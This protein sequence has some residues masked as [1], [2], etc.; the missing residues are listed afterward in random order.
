[1]FDSKNLQQR[2]IAGLMASLQV[3]TTPITVVIENVVKIV[4]VSTISRA[5]KLDELLI[6]H[7]L[8][9]ESSHYC[10]LHNYF[11]ASNR[12]R[13]LHAPVTRLRGHRTMVAQRHLL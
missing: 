12:T 1:M 4:K 13:D 10:G 9:N 2:L 8:Y 7:Q 5:N 11:R 3:P 6:Q